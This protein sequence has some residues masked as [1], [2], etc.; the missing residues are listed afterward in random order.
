MTPSFT[1]EFQ[2]LKAAAPRI[3]SFPLSHRRNRLKAL[4]AELIRRRSELHAAMRADLNR[5]EVDSDLNEL[6]P[7]KDSIDH[8]LAN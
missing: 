5:P 4:R 6:L 2:A 3:A 8:V 7:V 1:S